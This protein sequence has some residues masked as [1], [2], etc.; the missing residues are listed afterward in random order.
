VAGLRWAIRL[1]LAMPRD[2]RCAVNVGFE[3]LTGSNLI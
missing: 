1:S 2:C 3:A